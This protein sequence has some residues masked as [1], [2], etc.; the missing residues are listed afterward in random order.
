M[1]TTIELT[2]EARRRLQNL[3]K[4]WDERARAAA[5]DA[6]LAKVCFDRAKAAARWAQ[7]TGDMRAMHELAELLATWSAQ[8]EYTAATRHTA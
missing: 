5:T 7:R 8:T 3:A 2:P 1:S 4:T 6:E